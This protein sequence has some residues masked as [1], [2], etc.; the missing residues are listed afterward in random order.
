MNTADRLRTWRG[1]RG[2]NTVARE[3]GVS[4][5][6]W[7]SWETGRTTPPRLAEPAL[8]RLLGVPEADL[9]E[10]LN[11][12]RAARKAS[13]AG[14]PEAERRGVFP[15]VV[16][17]PS[18]ADQGLHDGQHTEGVAAEAQQPAAGAPA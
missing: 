4:W 10:L 8:A 6:T 7:Q 14:L 9:V 1:N 18:D 2:I 5:A 12:E 16:H 15:A 11:R 13:E 3:L 17:D